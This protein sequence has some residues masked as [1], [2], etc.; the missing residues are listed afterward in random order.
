MKKKEKISKTNFVTEV[1]EKNGGK[2]T[3]TPQFE[4]IINEMREANL[5]LENEVNT[6]KRKMEMRNTLFLCNYDPIK[7]WNL[8]FYK[9]FGLPL[10]NNHPRNLPYSISF[11]HFLDTLVIGTDQG[12]IN[13]FNTKREKLTHSQYIHEGNI[14][15]L[16]YLFDG[17]HIV[18]GGFDGRLI[19]YDMIDHAKTEVKFGE[20]KKIVSIMDNIRKDKLYVSAGTKLYCI[21]AYDLTEA[22]ENSYQFD[23]EISS[24]V[25]LDSAQ[26]ICLGFRSG[27]IRGYHIEKKKVIFEVNQIKKITDICIIDHNCENKFL[28]VAKDG[29]IYVIDDRGNA[30]LFYTSPNNGKYIRNVAYCY[31]KKSV[32]LTFKDGKFFLFNYVDGSSKEFSTNSEEKITSVYYFGDKRTL[33][34]GKNNSLEVYNFK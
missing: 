27:K 2:E 30:G 5:K 24:S 22:K 33:V 34:F 15:G 3:E 21:N 18:S 17:K 10:D 14:R 13:F 9:S 20:N 32:V 7:S 25:Y 29:S 23:D 4:I 16:V 11:N 26:I 6:L 28:S 12:Q 1:T 8:A 31:D 19:R